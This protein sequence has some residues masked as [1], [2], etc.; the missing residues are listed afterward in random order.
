MGLRGCLKNFLTKAGQ[1]EDLGVYCIK[2]TKL[3]TLH[4]FLVVAEFLRLSL[5]KMLRKLKS[6][7][8]VKKKIQELM[9]VK[10][11]TGRIIGISQS[12]VSRIWRQ[13]LGLTTFHKTK[14]QDL[15]DA[16]KLKRAITLQTFLVF[17]DV[18]S[19]TNFHL[20]RRLQ[21]VF[22]RPLSK[23]SSRRLQDVFKTSSRRL[24][25]RLQDVSARWLLQDVFKTS[26]RRCLQEDVLQLCLEDVFKTS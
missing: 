6:L 4:G 14:V 15:S 9:K 8:L 13:S 10:E 7:F 5:I 12:S 22:A 20:L 26:S 3:E 21:D 19:V 18:F 24:P 25:R 11:N 23:T 2:L 16:D 1:K 17:Q